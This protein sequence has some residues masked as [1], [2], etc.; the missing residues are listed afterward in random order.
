VSRSRTYKFLLQ[1]TNRQL[2]AIEY[3]LGLQRELYNAALEERRGTWKWNQR[4]V[5]YVDQTKELTQLRSV[6][7]DILSFGVTVCRGTLMR[8]HRSF[9]GFFRRCKAGEKPGFPRFKGPGSVR[10]RCNGA[11]PTAGPSMRPAGRLR[12][13]GIGQVKVHGCTGRSKGTPKAITIRREGKRYWVSVQCVD[14]PAEPLPATGKEHRGG[15]GRVGSLVATSDGQLIQGPRFGKRGQAGLEKAQRNLATK[16]PR[17]QDAG[18]RP[19][20]RVAAHHGKIAN[21]RRDFAHQTSRRLV[22]DHD[23]IVY[24]DLKIKNMTRRPKPRPDGNGGYEP[25][26]AKAKSGLNRSINDAGW[27]QFISMT[28]YK[29]ESAGREV[30][31]VD[32]RNTSRTCSGCG[33]VSAGNRH[34]AVFRCL[35]CGHEAH[36]DVNAAENILRAGRARRLIAA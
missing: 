32:P 13:Y 19:K 36:A 35:G 5:S 2:A 7:P 31:A 20:Q 14:V 16:V 26:G 4:S 25:N 10:L 27:G 21:R 3:L 15:P 1:P 12:L 29:A 23:L 28:I 8:L 6:R 17:F 22:N 18:R 34:G 11:T 24:E 33:H 30:I 9:E